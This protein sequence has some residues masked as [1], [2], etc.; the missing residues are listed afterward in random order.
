MFGRYSLYHCP[1]LGAKPR[2]LCLCVM[3]TKNVYV[4]LS[5]DGDFPAGIPHLTLVVEE[6]CITSNRTEASEERQL[7]LSGGRR[8]TSVHVKGRRKHSNGRL[9]TENSTEVALYGSSWRLRWRK[10][11]IAYCKA[12]II[13]HIISKTSRRLVVEWRVLRR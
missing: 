6:V 5:N 4:G 9:A 12:F 2:S 11:S 7:L 8:T 1:S 10:H 3:S 13:G